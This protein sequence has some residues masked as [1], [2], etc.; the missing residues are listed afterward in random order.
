M[1]AD[2]VN[3]RQLRKRKARG[4]KEAKAAQNRKLFGR[5]LKERRHHEAARLLEETKLSGK[6]R[7]TPGSEDTS[8]HD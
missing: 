2:I 8:D 3:L 7:I 6:Q 5:T 4:E 1:T